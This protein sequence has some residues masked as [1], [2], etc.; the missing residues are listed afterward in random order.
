M[1]PLREPAV[2]KLSTTFLNIHPAFEKK[3]IAKMLTLQ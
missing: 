3:K 2:S 1:K